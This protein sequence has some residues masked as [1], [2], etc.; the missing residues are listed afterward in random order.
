MSDTETQSEEEKEVIKR[1]VV[2]VRRYRKEVDGQYRPKQETYKVPSKPK[3]NGAPKRPLSAYFLFMND[4]RESYKESHSDLGFG[5][6]A[7]LASSEWKKMTNS[8]K[9]KY[10]E[11]AKEA[12]DQYKEER[13]KYEASNKYKKWKRDMK[14]WRDRYQEEW[15]EQEEQ[16]EI[17]RKERKEKREKRQKNKNKKEK[18]EKKEKKSNKKKG[19]RKKK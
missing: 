16:K 7:K 4:K 15:E 17:E 8:Q 13:K 12:S 11:K 2:T 9:K 18:K 10:T 14:E 3:Q 5:G 1:R 6:V 19:G